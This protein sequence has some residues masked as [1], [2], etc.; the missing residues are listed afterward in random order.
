MILFGVGNM[1][2]DVYDCVHALSKKAT[3]IVLNALE[4][5]RERTKG[6]E[7]RLQEL[8]ER[9]LITP[10]DDFAPEVGEEYFVVPT[11]SKKSA[12]IEFLK[13][14]YQ[15]PFAQLVHPTVYVSSHAKV[16]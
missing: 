3:S 14:T 1:L 13:N 8:N 15:L 9:P 4:Q 11:T 16:G 12:L 5:K 7:T 6:F 10:L 2:S